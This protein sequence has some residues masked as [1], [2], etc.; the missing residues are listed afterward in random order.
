M[1]IVYILI[2]LVTFYLLAIICDNYFVEALDK[3]SKKLKISQEITWA[4]FMAIGSSAPELFTSIFALFPLFKTSNGIEGLG[5][6]TIIG[7]A[8]FN[9][10]VIIGAAAIFMNWR[11]KWKKQK[12]KRQPIIRDLGFYAIT[13]GII[14]IS[15]RDWKIVLNE[16]IILV[17][18]Y[19]FYLFIVKNRWKR[20]KYD[21]DEDVAQEMDNKV[22]ESTKKNIITRIT[23]K[24]LD[25]IIP[26]CNKG[27]NRFRWTFVIS[28]TLIAVISHFMVDSAVHIAEILSMPTAIIWL[29]ILA[30]GTS[31]P[32][33]ISSIIVAK[34]GKWDMAITNALGSNIFDILFGLWAVYMVY[35]LVKP[36]IHYIP[37]DTHNLN[38]SVIL[39]FSTV[40]V[41]LALLIIQKREIKK[42]AGY[43]LIWSYLV[44]VIYKIITIL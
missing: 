20:L 43:F 24:G 19:F 28:I 27:K 14:L 4:T 12:I 17:A 35:L 18:F 9:V 3:I 5:A 26:S 11:R 23:I 42:Y 1:I 38:A 10:L 15:F 44:Y 33:L 30:A 22:E 2:L 7:S 8:I 31:V 25:F 32:D 13:I 16:T 37:V 40:I 6:G 29:T 41:L 36:E 39:L 34:Q 21:K